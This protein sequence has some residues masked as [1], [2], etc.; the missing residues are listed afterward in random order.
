M[1]K[2]MNTEMTIVEVNGVKMEIDLR[3]ARVVHQNIRVG[4]KVK[5]LAKGPYDNAVYPGVVIG[6]E[7]FKDLPTIIVA[8][9]KTS[10][11]SA[12]LMFAYINSKS[13][14]KWDIVPSVDDE[15]PIDRADVVAAFDR[16]IVQK[17]N[18]IR[19]IQGKRDFFLKHFNE[20]FVE[21]VESV[22]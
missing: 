13:S 18:E 2:E 5:V 4:T 17:E 3:Q 20:F 9:I 1:E 6:F 21:K 16:Q 11:A 12:E 14:D 8:Y 15:L 19:D 10:Y 22:F 7:P